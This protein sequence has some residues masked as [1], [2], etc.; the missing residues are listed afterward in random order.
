MYLYFDNAQVNVIILFNYLG[1]FVLYNV[2]LRILKNFKVS[3]AAL[4]KE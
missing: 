4:I 2:I 1:F 3:N